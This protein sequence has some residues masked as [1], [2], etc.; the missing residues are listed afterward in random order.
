MQDRRHPRSRRRK[1]QFQLTE[2]ELETGGCPSSQ[3]ATFKTSIPSESERAP[4]FA[5]F[6]GWDPARSHDSRRCPPEL[7]SEH[8][9]N[10]PKT[11]SPASQAGL[12]NVTS[13]YAVCQTP[14]L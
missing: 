13:R 7:R 12:T 9:R 4:S 6:E 11:K 8:F 1:A 5:V 10:L 14:L 2:R 3:R